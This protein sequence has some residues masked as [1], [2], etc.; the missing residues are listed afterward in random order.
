MCNMLHDILLLEWTLS[1]LLLLLPILPE[2]VLRAHVLRAVPH[3]LHFPTSALA[4]V[5]GRR[6]RGDGQLGRQ[7]SRVSAVARET[8]KSNNEL[9][10]H[11]MREME[12]DM[13]HLI[14]KDGTTLS[15]I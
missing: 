11:S 6:P 7:R 1:S 15:Y 2:T 9:S 5:R 13:L 4:A 12:F 8:D 10:V 14:L 3:R